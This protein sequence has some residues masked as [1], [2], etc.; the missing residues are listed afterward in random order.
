MYS[1]V[2]NFLPRFISYPTDALQGRYEGEEEEDNRHNA[3]PG[4]AAATPK[5]LW[6]YCRPETI[7]DMACNGEAPP[8]RDNTEGW[9]I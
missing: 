2:H 4:L 8:T 9:E 3:R 5:V 7:N 6:L 1:S